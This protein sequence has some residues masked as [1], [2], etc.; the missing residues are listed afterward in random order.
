MLYH[1]SQYYKNN[2]YFFLY[3]TDHKRQFVYGAI[4]F[5]LKEY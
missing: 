5:N 4:N 2:E 3:K 1:R